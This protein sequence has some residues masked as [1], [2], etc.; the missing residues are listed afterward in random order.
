MNIL[1]VA[2]WYP[3]NLNAKNG[4]FI[5]QH[6]LAVKAAGENVSVVHLAYSHRVVVPEIKLVVKSGIQVFYIFIPRVLKNSVRLEAF[7]FNR[8]ISKLDDRGFTPDIIHGHVVFPSGYL[9]LFLKKHFK[10]PL[11]FTEHWSGYKE[12]NSDLFTDEVHEMTTEVLNGTDLI[13]PVSA[14]LAENMIAKG[15]R[16][17]YSVVNNTVDTSVFYPKQRDDTGVFKFIHVSNFDARA[18]N[19]EGIISA[20]TK[21]GFKNAK[22]TIAGDGD[23]EKIREYAKSLGADISQIDFMGALEYNEV[24]HLMRNSDCFVLFSNFENLPCVIAESHCCGIPV[25]ATEVG[26]IPEMI[27]QT[28]GILV[29]AGDEEA[30]IAGMKNMIENSNHFNRTDIAEV[31]SQRYSYESIGCEFKKHYA[32]LSRE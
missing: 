7:M 5:E 3:S 11:V 16:G 22:L 23:I 17:N 20:F 12:V 14:D 29:P 4:N 8:L 25:L 31:A 1:F 32:A 2:S 9:A 28:N 30:L 6:A 10:V 15:F 21:G 13:L 19:T 24:A 26:G 27:D 18:K